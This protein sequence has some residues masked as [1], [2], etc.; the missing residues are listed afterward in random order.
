MKP[1]KKEPGRLSEFEVKR[2]KT[3]LVKSLAKFRDE[4][5]AFENYDVK[6]LLQTV[7][8][9]PDEFS[10]QNRKAGEWAMLR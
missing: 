8:F 6:N 10:S 7:W 4:C 3:I 9:F 2:P 1:K 5:F